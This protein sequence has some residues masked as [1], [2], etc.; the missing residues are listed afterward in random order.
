MRSV[1]ERVTR[2]EKRVPAYTFS[3]QVEAGKLRE[4]AS[5]TG[6]SP[7]P[8][9]PAE[10]PVVPP[11]FL[12]TAECWLP[13]GT[14]PPGDKLGFEIQRAL[15]GEQEFSIFRPIRVGDRLHGRVWLESTT[16]KLGKRGGRMRFCVW[17]TDFD[18]EQGKPVAQAK[19]TV[20]E[21]EKRK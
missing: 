18:D 13:P 12:A 5:A 19:M 15:H 8:V 4:F 10:A 16:S 11:T 20:I 1:P 6:Y 7:E 2:T 3:M 17:V 9:T 14:W 21:T